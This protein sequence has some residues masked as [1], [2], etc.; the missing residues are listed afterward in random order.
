MLILGALIVAAALWWASQQLVAE[1]RATR[2]EAA[3]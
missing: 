1:L 2:D 3:R